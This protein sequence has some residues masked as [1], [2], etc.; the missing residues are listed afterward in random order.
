MDAQARI[1]ML[2]QRMVDAIANHDFPGARRYS[3]EERLARDE[4]H[5]LRQRYGIADSGND[6]C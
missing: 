2:I 3:D 5:R 6:G 4:L 1:P